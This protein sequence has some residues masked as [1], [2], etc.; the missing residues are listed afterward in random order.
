MARPYRTSSPSSAPRRVPRQS[1]GRPPPDRKTRLAQ[2]IARV[3]K[4]AVAKQ[5]SDLLDRAV[6][7]LALGDVRGAAE[8]AKRASVLAPR[9]AGA[10]EVLGMALY[11]DELYREALR[12]LQTYKRLSGRADQNH[13]I[14]DAFRALGSPEK[15]IPLAEEALRTQGIPDEAKAEAAVVGASALGDLGRFTEALTLLRRWRIAESGAVRQWDLRVWYVTAD[16]LQKAGRDQDARE[17]FQRILRHDADAFDVRERL[18]ALGVAPPPVRKA[19]EGGPTRKSGRAPAGGKGRARKPSARKPAPRKPAARKPA[20]R[21]RGAASGGRGGK[22]AA[23]R[24]A[25]PRSGARTSTGKPSAGKHAAR[26]AAAGKPVRKPAVKKPAVRKPAVR[27][28]AAKRS[29]SRGSG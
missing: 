1:G 5:A 16:V 15:A 24:A 10:R 13:L 26:K 19:P 27:K 6:D 23:R 12:E 20:P 22:P 29:S 17:E 28:P 4:P 11:Q 18:E 2:D 3:A 9:S 25:Q 8:A 7:K 21:P 14:A